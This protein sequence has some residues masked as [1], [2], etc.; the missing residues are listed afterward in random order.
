MVTTGAPERVAFEHAGFRIAPTVNRHDG[1]GTASVTVEF[2]NGFLELIYP[3]PSVP[4]SPELAAGAEKFRMKSAWRKNGT[5]PIGLVFDRTSD[6]PYKLPFETW[7]VSADWMQRGTFIEMM[8]P[9]NLINAPSLS[10]S[11]QTATA[12]EAETRNLQQDSAKSSVFL[13]PN[14][15]RRLSGV[16]VIAPSRDVLPP[17]A[18]FIAEH[19][20]AQFDLGKEWMLDVT[21]DN[22]R[23]AV[24]R[25]LAPTLPIVV[26]Y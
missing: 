24:T 8:T 20:L 23:Q 18:A 15:A 6:T 1:Q 12:R 16:R 25:S 9:R 17:A 7:K 19:N 5:S 22:A 14:G 13:H 11:S 26:H 3:D 2:V 10:I 21:L 4:V